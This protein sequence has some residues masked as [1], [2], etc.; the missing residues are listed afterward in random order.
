[1][2]YRSLYALLIALFLLPISGHSA[3]L[4]VMGNSLIWELFFILA[5]LSLFFAYRYNT[6]QRHNK[7]LIELARHDQLTGLYNRRM[8]NQSLTDS[9]AIANRYNRPLSLIFF[10]IDDFKRV[11]DQHGH[12]SGDEVLIQVAELLHKNCR[13]S[14]SFGRWGG[15]E[16]L[17]ILPESPLNNAE[18][19]AEKLRQSIAQHYFQT[20]TVIKLTCSFGI[21]EYQPGESMDNFVNRADQ[22]LYRAKSAGKNCVCKDE[23]P[24]QPP[25]SSS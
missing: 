24:F 25:E 22:A 3:F 19:S 5:A 13:Q 20:K 1:M 17:I 6:I 15:E 10:D 11:N 18:H 4:G 23:S 21:A 9:V 2:L 8:L 7:E 12:K 16:F 14:D